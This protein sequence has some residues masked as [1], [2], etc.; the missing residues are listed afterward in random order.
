MRATRSSPPGAAWKSELARVQPTLIAGST[1]LMASTAARWAATLTSK[2][3]CVA[4][5]WKPATL[6]AVVPSA[7]AAPTQ[8]GLFSRA[9]GVASHRPIS[10]R[11]MARLGSFMVQTRS[12]MSPS[13][14]VTRRQ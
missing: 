4:D 14:A 2:A 6:S 1:P 13:S 9:P 5:S 8:V 3:S 10:R 7:R 12:N 11:R